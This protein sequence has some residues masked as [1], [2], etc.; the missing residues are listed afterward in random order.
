MKTS[1]LMSMA[2]GLLAGSGINSWAADDSSFQNQVIPSTTMVAGTSQTIILQ[3]FNEGDTTWT[4]AGG[5][6]IGSQNPQ[7]N[8]TWGTNR[9]SLVPDNMGPGCGVAFGVFIVAPAIPGNYNLQ[10]QLMHDGLPFGECSTNKVITV[11]PPPTSTSTVYLTFTGTPT[12]TNTP[13]FTARPTS[14]S[15]STV[16]PSPTPSRTPASTAT[17]FPTNLATSTAS[18]TPT[19][20]PPPTLTFTPTLPGIPST[21]ALRADQVICY[22]SPATGDAVWFCYYATDLTRARV[23]IYNLIGEKIADLNTP[24]GETGYQRLCWDIRRVATGIYFYR[25]K[26]DGTENPQT[27]KLHKLVITKR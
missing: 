21:P 25:L 14:S 15:T 18:P 10:W 24:Q 17:K 9:V 27:V 7:G 16:T 12:A 6:Y 13:V 5:Y 19:Q 22:P 2:F 26:T 8:T 1:L 23:E 4:N 3:W 20:T 11:I